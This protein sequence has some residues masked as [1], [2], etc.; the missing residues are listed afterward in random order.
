MKAVKTAS[1]LVVLGTYLYFKLIY[2]EYGTLI[3]FNGTELYYTENVTEDVAIRLGDYLVDEEFA[4]GSEKTVQ[5]DKRDGTYQFRL[6][7]L[8]V[9]MFLYM[10]LSFLVWCLAFEPC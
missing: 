6:I 10:A 2:E 9:L 1:F 8:L 3:E 7:T 4:D 5:L